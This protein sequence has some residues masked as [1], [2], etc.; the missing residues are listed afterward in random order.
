M[1]EELLQYI[2][3]YKYLLSQNLF[4]TKGEP[5]RVLLPG[6][7]NTDSGPDFFNAR[8]L[9]DQTLWAGN[10]EIHIKSSDWKKHN[11]HH[12]PAYNNV[13]LHVVLEHDEPIFNIYDEVI[14]TLELKTLLAPNLISRYQFLKESQSEIP[15]EK[16]F[17]RPEPIIEE[18]WFE[19]LSIERLENKYDSIQTLFIQTNKNWDQVFYYLTAKYFGQKTNELPFELIAKQLPLL[20]LA[21][22]KESL[23]QTQA[24]VL[25]IAGLLNQNFEDDYLRLLK[26]EFR[27]L[28]NKYRLESI[29]KVIWKFGRTRPTNFPGIRLLQFAQIVHQSNHLLSTILEAKNMEEAASFF[30]IQ[31]NQLIDIGA[32][33]GKS[34]TKKLTTFNTGKHFVNLMMINVVVPVLFAYGKWDQ[35]ETY[36]LRAL[37]WLNLLKPEDNYIIKKWGKLGIKAQNAKQTQAIIGLNNYYCKQHNCLKCAFG[38]TILNRKNE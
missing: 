21:R 6:Q 22:N 37:N 29:D 31:S 7:L 23:L 26:R 38:N 19:R 30:Q 11:H 20:I 8:I 10:I 14:P 28:Q 34:H 2:W 1:H 3:Q 16:I 18:N 32:L 35:N 17:I 9:L 4:T 24:L 13:I 25:G 27:A 36:C 33:N 15:C 5:I 12:D